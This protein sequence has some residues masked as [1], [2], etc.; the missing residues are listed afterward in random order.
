MFIGLW[1]LAV[2]QADGPYGAPGCSL[3]LGF[4]CQPEPPERWGGS[5]KAHTPVASSVPSPP[6]GV[7]ELMDSTFPPLRRPS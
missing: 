5:R 1:L 6:S 2:T 4:T 7:G 3:P